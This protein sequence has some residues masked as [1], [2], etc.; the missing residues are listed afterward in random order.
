MADSVEELV[1]SIYE[2]SVDPVQWPLAMERAERLIGAFTSHI[3]LCRCGRAEVFATA[4]DHAQSPARSA[5]AVGGSQ[6]VIIG[7]VAH[8]S[9]YVRRNPKRVSARGCGS[10]S[11]GL[12]ATTL[13]HR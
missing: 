8:S 1:S 10:F 6:L 3:L 9:Q 13:P 5:V 7:R 4:P 12:A 2:A 11:T